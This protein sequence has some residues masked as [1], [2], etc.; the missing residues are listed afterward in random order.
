[1]AE[2]PIPHY[3]SIKLA[4]ALQ[5]IAPE[6]QITEAQAKFGESL[7]S[8]AKGDYS[9]IVHSIL[10]KKAMESRGEGANFDENDYLFGG[11]LIRNLS[12]SGDSKTDL[13]DLVAKRALLIKDLKDKGASADEIAVDLGKRG[14]VQEEIVKGSKIAALAEISFLNLINAGGWE[15]ENPVI[16]NVKYIAEGRWGI[17]HE[18]TQLGFKTINKKIAMKKIN[19]PSSKEM[20]LQAQEALLA[21]VASLK[22]LHASKKISDEEKEKIIPEP[23]VINLGEFAYLTKLKTGNLTE[24]RNLN[25]QQKIIVAK[26]L[27]EQ[28]A[29]FAKAGFLYTDI[30]LSNVLV[31][32]TTDPITVFLSDCGNCHFIDDPSKIPLSGLT[33]TRHCCLEEDVVLLNEAVTTSEDKSQKLETASQILMS[34]A[35]GLLLSQLFN[36][37][38]NDPFSKGYQMQ[39]LKTFLTKYPLT[40]LQNTDPHLHDTIMGML[41]INGPQLKP[42]EAWEN[43][44]IV[45]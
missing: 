3:Q 30:K 26:Q 9:V 20:L 8:D 27:I 43:L 23:I 1:M 6:T 4:E 22:K 7:W 16:T 31:D 24:Y 2:D 36:G 39:D 34:R 42:Q 35:L 5:E 11:K 33:V 29:I 44:K 45:L 17:V 12:G 37:Q 25:L 14:T 18:I 13:Y 41:G 10:L 21:E 19:P 38:M 40:E 15:A 28:M 32:D